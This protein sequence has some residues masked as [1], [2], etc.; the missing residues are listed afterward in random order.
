M[1]I[2]DILKYYILSKCS[3]FEIVYILNDYS[4]ARLLNQ[5][6]YCSKFTYLPDPYVNVNVGDAGVS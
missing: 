6:F 1:K 3:V 5:K 4:S 2:L